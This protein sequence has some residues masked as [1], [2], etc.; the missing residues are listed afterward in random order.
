MQLVLLLQLGYLAL[1]LLKSLFQSRAFGLPINQILPEGLD[2]RALLEQLLL[3]ETLL[4]RLCPGFGQ[5]TLIVSIE[6]GQLFQLGRQRLLEIADLRLQVLNLCVMATQVLFTLH[7]AALAEMRQSIPRMLM[8][9]FQR[10][11][12]AGAF[13]EELL[14]P[15]LGGQ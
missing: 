4:L 7:A 3:Q 15:R 12:L 1:F 5:E 14:Q 8:L 2:R 13:V 9:V 6:R 10:T 11:Q